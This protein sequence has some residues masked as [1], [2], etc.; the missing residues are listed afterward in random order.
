MSGIRVEGNTSGN[1]AEVDANNQLKITGNLTQ[2]LAG[3][4][5]QTTETDPGTIVRIGVGIDI[6]IRVGI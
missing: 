6:G 2:S 3:F 4:E 5:S 1:V